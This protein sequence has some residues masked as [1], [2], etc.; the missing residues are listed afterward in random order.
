MPIQSRATKP[1][2]FMLKSTLDTNTHT[3]LTKETPTNNIVDHPMMG[4]YALLP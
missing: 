2:P 1:H 3:Y 4:I